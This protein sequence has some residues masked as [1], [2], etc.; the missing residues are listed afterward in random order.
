[1][2]ARERVNLNLPANWMA[3]RRE[4]I[5]RDKVCQ[6]CGKHGQVVHHI[7]FD[8]RRINNDP[9]NLV[10]LCWPCHISRHNGI[11]YQHPVYQ[12]VEH[13]SLKADC[14]MQGNPVVFLFPRI[15]T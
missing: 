14:H 2:V 8:Q 15:I 12:Q 5:K 11:P 13:L 4:V 1:M 3:I 9:S 7:D 6:D 10:Y